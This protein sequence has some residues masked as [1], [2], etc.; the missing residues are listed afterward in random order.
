MLHKIISWNVAARLL[1]ALFNFL[2]VLAVSRSLGP[3]AKGETTLWITLIFIGVFASN[4]SAG[5]ALLNYLKKNIRANV[6]LPSY[7][8]SIAVCGL[9]AICSCFFLNREWHFGL[10]IW[11]L[12]TVS[13]FTSANQTLL[14]S[15]QHFK[16]FNFLVF[17]QAFWLLLSL[18]LLL[19][20]FHSKN[21]DSFLIALYISVLSSFLISFILILKHQIAVGA[22]SWK[23]LK[24]ITLNGFPFQLA[25][26]LQL[27]HLRLYFFLLAGSN[28][29]GLYQLGIYSVGISILESVWIFSR[30]VATVNFAATVKHPSAADTLRWLRLSLLFSLFALTAVFAVPKEVYAWVFGEGFLYVKYS[31]KYLFP[32]IGFYVFVLVLGSYFMG[33]ERYLFMSAV[34]VLGIIVSVVLCY[35]LIPDYEMSGAGLAASISFAAAAAMVLFYFLQTEKISLRELMLKKSD[36]HPEKS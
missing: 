24:E 33:K 1:S 18:V 19:Y 13:S 2:V 34:H 3:V 14:L 17:C 20:V 16:A 28:E 15:R 26:L 30:S 22:F 11:V 32:G 4:I 23:E 27:L 31:V 25:E 7:V 21:I 35:F 8:W 29:S 36:F 6:L 9:V 10:H 5:F 12:A